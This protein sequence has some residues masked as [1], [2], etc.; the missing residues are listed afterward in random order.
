MVMMKSTLAVLALCLAGGAVYAQDKGKPKKPADEGSDVLK[1]VDKRLKAQADEILRAVQKMLEDRLGKSRAAE[2]KKETPKKKEVEAKPT[3]DDKASVLKEV[4]KR[5]KAQRESILAAV[6]RMLDERLGKGRRAYEEKG[7]PGRKAPAMQGKY[8]EHLPP[9]Q[10]KRRMAER[11]DEKHG[12][13]PGKDGKKKR[14][15]DDDDD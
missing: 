10:A 5:L 13:M 12:K 4:D 9:G 3:V 15:K 8:A 7:A 14:G 6:A 1:D 11:H 2:E